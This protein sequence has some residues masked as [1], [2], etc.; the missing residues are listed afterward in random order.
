LE[1]YN[2]IRAIR[3]GLGAIFHVSWSCLILRF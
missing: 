3:Y 1:K 2:P